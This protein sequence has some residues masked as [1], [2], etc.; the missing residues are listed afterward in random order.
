V[1]GV[2]VN[3]NHKNFAQIEM[4]ITREMHWKV[5][6]QK[7]RAKQ[8]QI[9]SK[10]WNIYFPIKRQKKPALVWGNFEQDSINA[11][12]NIFS[13][14]L[15]GNPKTQQKCSNLIWPSVVKS[16][17]KKS[18]KVTKTVYSTY[19]LIWAEVFWDLK[20]IIVRERLMNS[21]FKCI[22][23]EGP[24]L[25]ESSILDIFLNPPANG[26]NEQNKICVVFVK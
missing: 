16:C 8:K 19:T 15:K 18:F 26:A 25:L 9:Q 1:N 7:I 12:T 13:S 11:K 21:T 5:L 20:K 3:Y 10:I 6:D 14:F 2:T 23:K 22:L 4:Q 24:L 17:Y